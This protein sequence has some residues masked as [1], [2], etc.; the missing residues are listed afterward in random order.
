[1]LLCFTNYGCFFGLSRIRQPHI[2][3]FVDD[4]FRPLEGLQSHVPPRVRLV[5]M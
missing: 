4:V 1:M 2:N 5:Q 3:V